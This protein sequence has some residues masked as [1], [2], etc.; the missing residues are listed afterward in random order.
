METP[1]LKAYKQL[2]DG[3]ASLG[4]SVAG[5]RIRKGDPIFTGFADKNEAYNKLLK[6]LDQ[7]TREMIA[8]LLDQAKSGGIHDTLAFLES[9]GY[10]LARERVK[11]AH[12]P[13]GTEM[14]F[15]FVSRREGD[16]WPE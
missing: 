2:I 4:A 15:D 12:Q 5:T 16:P 11:L 8:D 13:F 10:E 7:D 6:H 1:E 9:G 14:F 3:L